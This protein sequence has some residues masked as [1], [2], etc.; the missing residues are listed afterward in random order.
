MKKKCLEF[1]FCFSNVYVQELNERSSQEF[2]TSFEKY[3]GKSWEILPYNE[4]GGVWHRVMLKLDEINSVF[5]FAKKNN[6]NVHLCYVSCMKTLNDA[7][8]YLQNGLSFSCVMSFD[9]LDLSTNIKKTPTLLEMKLQFSSGVLLMSPLL[10]YSIRILY[11]IDMFVNSQK[12][13]DVCELILSQK[14]CIS[15]DN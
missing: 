15:N 6:L 13:E 7:N 3:I 11:T 9:C 1:K 4:F 14:I 2:Y 8:F 5:V 12:D 10:F